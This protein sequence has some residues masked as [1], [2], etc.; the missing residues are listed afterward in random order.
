MSS[1]LEKHTKKHKE[2]KRYKC[3]TCGKVFCTQSIQFCFHNN[4]NKQQKKH[5]TYINVS[6]EFNKDQD[7]TI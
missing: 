5:C 7:T 6:Q 3:E 1:D 4:Q 2:E